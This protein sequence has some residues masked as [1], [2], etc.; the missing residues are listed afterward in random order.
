VMRAYTTCT[1]DS[2]DL[3]T[4]VCTDQHFLFI[5]KKTGAVVKVDTSGKPV[6]E[7]DLSG[8]K[9]KIKYDA[10]VRDWACLELP[11]GSVIYLNY[12]QKGE[13]SDEYSEWQ[14]LLNLK[15]KRL[16]SNREIPFRKWPG[17]RKAYYW[18]QDT[19]QAKFC[20]VLTSRG[21]RGHPAPL[22]YF[23]PIQIFKTDRTDKYSNW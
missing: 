4:A 2:H 3:E 19:I 16:G 15:G 7:R 12:T 5:N 22:Y 1:E 8:G 18:Y 9:I 14:E 20:K 10:V 13:P 21:F 17:S 11:A 6:V 23:V